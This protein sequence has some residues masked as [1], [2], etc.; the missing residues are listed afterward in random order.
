M[1]HFFEFTLV[2]LLTATWIIPAAMAAWVIVFFA[3][4]VQG[5]S[6]KFASSPHA[7]FTA[8]VTI[9]GGILLYL[10]YAGSVYI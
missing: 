9:L 7:Y 1:S 5:A 6:Q 2:L 4:K 8:L 3:R 10:I